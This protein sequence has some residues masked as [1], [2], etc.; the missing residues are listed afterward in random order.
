VTC[1]VQKRV[2]FGVA[3]TVALLSASCG[4]GGSATPKSQSGGTASFA[5][6][7]SQQINYIFP[8]T[9]GQYL[10][11]PNTQYFQYL[12]WRPLYWYGG[13]GGPQVNYSLSVGNQ[14]TFSDGGK[15]VTI[16]L[17]H[18]RW[19]DGQP[20][21]S[22]DIEFWQNLVTA[23]KKDWGDYTP[24]QYPDNIVSAS[25]PSQ[26]SFSLTFNQA[27][28]Q[29]WIINN[30]LSQIIPIP[31]QA[32]DKT[33]SS[34][35]VGDNDTSPAGAVAVYK[36]LNAQS[37]S[38]QTWTTN[39]LWKVIDGPWKLQSYSSSTGS[40]SFVPNGAYAGPSK[41]KLDQLK[42]VAVTSDAAELNL[43]LSGGLTYGYVPKT[44]VAQISQLKS[45]GYTVQAWPTWG[46]DFVPYNFTNP[47]TGPIL[48]QLYVRQAIQHL[49]DQE[50]Y[51]KAFLAGYGTPEYGPVVTS[52]ANPW[53]SGSSVS[54]PYPYSISDAKQLLAAHGWTAG[55]GGVV[56]CTRPGTGASDCGAGIAANTPL[57]LSLRIVSGATIA[58]QE[59]QA[60]E[61]SMASAGMKLTITETTHSS[62][63]GTMAPCTQS[64]PATCTWDMQWWGDGGQDWTYDPNF[65]PSLGVIFGTGG[66]FNNGGYSDPEADRLIQA[67]VS[68]T[69]SS[70][71]ALQAYNQYLAEQ[72]PV[73]WMPTGPAQLSAISNKLQ[74]AFPQNPNLWIT[75][76]SWTLSS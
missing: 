18:Y 71:S 26:Y 74:G 4:G 51:I 15:T 35:A 38:L 64:A 30:E 40:A 13:P 66:G 33:S 22:R 21:T 57:A 61:S 11:I 70:S 59:A 39:P 63:F 42:I 45:D 75:P 17:K 56:E 47:T 8:L 31:H 76:E 7:P 52:P 27:Y 65:Y 34:A 53:V 28:N 58:A 6:A 73:L 46:I 72:L 49:V 41:A 60:L 32:W 2:W 25:Y 54:N 20:V 44:N 29:D 69:G 62:I 3:T 16:T 67:T 1:R 24:G 50:G 19:S 5:M 23:N 9:S 36:Y 14:P 37:L 48:K 68:N 43:L 10:T 12:M 55:S